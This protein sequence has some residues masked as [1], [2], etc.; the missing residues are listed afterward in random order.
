MIQNTQMKAKH[1]QSIYGPAHKLRTNN[2][3]YIIY[4][5]LE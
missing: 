5:M 3:Y 1:A 4:R 2:L